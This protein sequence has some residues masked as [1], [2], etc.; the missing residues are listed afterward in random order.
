MKK[1]LAAALGA[2]TL[3]STAA[4]AEA[5]TFYLGKGTEDY[6]TR[7]GDNV[8]N[9]YA[10]LSSIGDG[11]STIKVDTCTVTPCFREGSLVMVLQMT[12]TALSKNEVGRWELAR[13]KEVKKEEDKGAG[14]G[15]TLTLTAPLIH[16]YAAEMTQV[17]WVPE[18]KNVTINTGSTLKAAQEW[19]GKVGGVVA[20]LASGVVQND[21]KITVS[22]MGFRGG[23]RLNNS[24]A[25]ATCPDNTALNSSGAPKGEGTVTGH[26]GSTLIGSDSVGNGGGGG[27]CSSFGGGGGGNGGTGGV[28][29]GA[30]GGKGG[31][32]LQVTRGLIG[33]LLLGGGGGAGHGNENAS[34]KESYGRGGGIVFIRG[35][36]LKG[37]GSI[38]AAGAAGRAS[39]STTGGG[40]SGG[41]AG[42]SIYLRFAGT[43][44]CGIKSFNATGGI[45][46]G[47]NAQ[48]AGSGGGGGGGRM[49]FQAATSTGD[50]T[51]RPELHKDA[52][53][54]ESTIIARGTTGAIQLGGFAGDNGDN[55]SFERLEA[56]ATPS[57][58][59]APLSK[60]G[61][62]KD[63]RPVIQGQ[64][65]VSTATVR[66]GS[67][68]TVIIFIDGKE[69][70]RTPR[71]DGGDY[72]FPRLPALPNLSDGRYKVE[73]VN[74][75]D[76]MRSP[77]GS[78]FT[79]TVDTT[80]PDAK[81][82]SFPK[83]ITRET[84]AK[85][86][87][88]H[89]KEKEP[90]SVTYQCKLDTEA[91][92][93][94]CTGLETYTG[95]PEGEH[96]FQV[97]ATDEAGN[98]DPTLA[99]YKWIV[100][101]TPPDTK[102]VSSPESTTREA[103]ATFH[104]NVVTPEDGVTYQCKLDTDEDF[105]ACS[106]P[107]TYAGLPDGERTFQVRAVDEAGNPDLSAATYTWTVDTGDY[108]LG[109]KGF[110]CSA[111]GG[112]STLVLM[113]LG[114]FLALARRRRQN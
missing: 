112:D 75:V 65:N 109:G 35:N 13:V 1:C 6:T 100:D 81:I 99:T 57:A 67:N 91:G 85:F 36:T 82:D 42:G 19:N 70:G 51:C 110:G 24:S 72:S 76:G 113:G 95:L 61:I 4:L 52:K 16:G 84:S 105:K 33:H 12:G 96:T 86:E 26:Y 21:G 2:L 69:V 53:T 22:K 73:A 25:S 17:I 14:P 63:S 23:D 111:T 60:N 37:V 77:L 62:T 31:A 9:S 56:V 64:T 3:G 74:E 102:I 46:G 90:G 45:G 38:E 30:M 83:R 11:K 49:L 28:G 10:R 103:D 68:A 55:G 87:F 20:F 104:F 5:D 54:G 40:G 106:G 43:A 66:A 78:A 7:G 39:E 15:A 89:D 59:V 58:V 8:I 71:N 80:P 88:S 79:F 44:S 34:E 50:N 101:T 48:D 41:G 114:S 93:K 94:A 32:V 92:F 47:S 108:S 97:L 29:G 98:P 107:E 18:Y 27:V